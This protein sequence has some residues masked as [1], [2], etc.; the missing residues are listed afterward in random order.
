[1][2]YCHVASNSMVEEADDSPFS[3][4]ELD[5]AGWHIP[6]NELMAVAVEVEPSCPTEVVMRTHGQNGLLNAWRTISGWT[7][8]SSSVRA[9]PNVTANRDVKRR[10]VTP[11]LGFG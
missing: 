7:P 10:L 9:L 8:A 6:V 2:G 11:P 5:G 4:F 3:L 1:M